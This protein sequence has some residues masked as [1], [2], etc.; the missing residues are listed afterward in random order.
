LF[1]RVIVDLFNRLV[2]MLIADEFASP[3]SSGILFC[4]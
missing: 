3:D 4:V 1:N 2:A